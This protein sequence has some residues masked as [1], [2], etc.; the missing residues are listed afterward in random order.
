MEGY[1]AKISD[2]GSI[3]IQHC[4][5]PRAW[6]GIWGAPEK[7]TPHGLKTNLTIAKAQDLYSLG[8]SIWSVYLNGC[9]PFY[10]QQV[11]NLIYQKFGNQNEYLDNVKS[12]KK[13]ND[14]WLLDIILITFEKDSSNSHAMKILEAIRSLCRVKAGAR[15]I[16]KALKSLAADGIV[17]TFNCKPMTPEWSNQ[18]FSAFSVQVRQLPVPSNPMETYFEID[19]AVVRDTSP[20]P[21]WINLYHV[22]ISQLFLI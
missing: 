5:R 21:S 13:N 16:Q 15:D 19:A 22:S 17:S 12:L 14:D 11:S 10:N 9:V 3:S 1:T 4:N 7:F 18:C 8:L 2:F 20:S 6:H